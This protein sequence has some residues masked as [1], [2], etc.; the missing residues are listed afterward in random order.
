[1]SP[2][3]ILSLGF[4]ICKIGT[5]GV[6]PGK[7]FSEELRHCVQSINLRLRTD[8]SSRDTSCY[9]YSICDAIWGLPMLPQKRGVP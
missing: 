5:V 6:Y 8:E 9:D 1:M 7:I 4:L 2:S 3:M